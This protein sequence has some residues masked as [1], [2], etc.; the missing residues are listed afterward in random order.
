[1]KWMH[2]FHL[3]VPYAVLS[4]SSAL[5]L[6]CVHYRLNWPEK[7]VYQSG[8]RSQSR[9]RSWGRSESTFLA[10]VGIGAEIG[11]IFT[12]SYSGPESQ[13]WLLPPTDDYFVGAV[14]HHRENNEKQEEKRVAVRR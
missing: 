9:D 11:T 10:A 7:A 14:F 4:N 3:I 1:M 12:D 5:F 2:C 8:L 6:K 13:T